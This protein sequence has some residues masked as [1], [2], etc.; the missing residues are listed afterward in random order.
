MYLLTVASQAY[1]VNLW[2]EN[3][4]RG[5]AAVLKCQISSF[6]H[7]YVSVMAWLVQAADGTLEVEARPESTPDLPGT[8][9]APRA[10]PS[11]PTSPP[12]LRDVACPRS[13]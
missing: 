4:L 6:V 2:E 7:E 13:V 9:L 11:P 10:D 8:D 1:T 5:N 3:V 12:A